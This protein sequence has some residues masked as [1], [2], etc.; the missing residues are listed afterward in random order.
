MK[1]KEDNKSKIMR[2]KVFI[3]YYLDIQLIYIILFK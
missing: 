2:E 3:Y 1:N